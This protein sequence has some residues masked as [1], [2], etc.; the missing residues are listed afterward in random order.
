MLVQT[1]NFGSLE[2]PEDKV[3]IFREGLPGFSQIHRF[4]VLEMETLKPL[5]YLQSLDEPPISLFVINP[6]L[7]DPGYEFQLTDSEMEDIKAA[8]P[9]DLAV[10]V[11]ATIP[12]NPKDATLNFMA[13]I[14]I[15]N[16][17]RCGK[18]VILQDSKYSVK[19]PLL[20]SADQDKAEEQTA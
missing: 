15:N 16:K 14:V 11:I 13:P 8:N 17:D 1:I 3:L 4:A 6:F 10:Y 9:A 19:H 2:I 18:Q 12:E 20:H 7:I 5:Q